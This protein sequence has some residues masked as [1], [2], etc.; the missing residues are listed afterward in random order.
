M[1]WV[2]KEISPGSESD[3]SSPP[4]AQVNVSSYT[5]TVPSVFLGVILGY[6]HGLCS[7][8][9]KVHEESGQYRVS[10]SPQLSVRPYVRTQ[11]LKDSHGILH[12][13][14]LLN[15][16]RH[17]RVADK[18]LALQRKQQAT[19]LKKC[20]YSTYSPLISIHLW[21]RC[22]DFFNPSKKDSFGCAANRKSQR[23]ISTPTY[24]NFD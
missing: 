17:T 5:F 3:Q 10:V 23:L 11:P 12:R 16:A 1:K 2:L 4:G 8:D 21:L 6:E 9:G 15:L 22:S 14:V 19:G 18:S 13:Q 24:L 7:D 20:I